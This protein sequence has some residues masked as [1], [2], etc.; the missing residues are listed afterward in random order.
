M[1]KYYLFR[2]EKKILDIEVDKNIKE[3]RLQ[4]LISENESLK[5][6]INTYA[7]AEENSRKKLV[8]NT[9]E[10]NSIKDKYNNIKIQQNSILQENS[11]LKKENK[12]L[13]ERVKQ[14]INE[15]ILIF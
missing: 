9:T 7:V 12:L 14:I 4:N 6:Q 2:S 10:I 5:N 13:L 1:S 15:Y 3:N 8:E 11:S